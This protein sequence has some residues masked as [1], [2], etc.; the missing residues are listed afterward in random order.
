MSTRVGTPYVFYNV[1]GFRGG[2][3]KAV[4]SFDLLDSELRDAENVDFG[5]KGSIVPRAGTRT[6]D[7]GVG[8][9]IAADRQT[10]IKNIFR[11][12]QIDGKREVVIQS[13]RFIYND[14]DTGT[15]ANLVEMNQG[16]DGFIRFAQW[17]DTMF[18]F[19]K[20]DDVK[21]YHR[22]ADTVIQQARASG[23]TDKVF[24]V[25]ASPTDGGLDFP[26]TYYYRFTFERY[27]GDDFLGETNPININFSLFGGGVPDAS[28]VEFQQVRA[29]NSSGERGIVISS[30]FPPS[31]PLTALDDV[32]FINV[33]RST[34]RTS[35]DPVTGDAP[36]PLLEDPNF[37]FI[38]QF[39]REDYFRETGFSFKD[40]GQKPGH[41]IRYQKKSVPPRAKFAVM[42]KTRM[43]YANI[44]AHVNN[45]TPI[46]ANSYG[47]YYSDLLEPVAVR[48]LSTF[49]INPEDGEEIAQIVSW[50]GKALFV[51][52]D[53]SISAVFGGD[54]EAIDSIGRTSGVIDITIETIDTAVGC[55]APDSLAKGEGG[56]MFLSNRGVY[57]FNGVQAISLNSEIIEP[58]LDDIPSSMRNKAAGIYLNKERRYVL[59]ISNL[60]VAPSK[61]TVTLVYDFFTR[62]WTKYKFVGGT[63]LGINKYVELKRGDETG[64]LLGT[65][66]LSGTPQLAAGGTAI[67]GDVI[68]EFNIAMDWFATTK[69]FDCGKPHLVKNFTKLIIRYKS[70]HVLTIDYDVDEGKVV[71]TE[72]IP[73]SGIHTWDEPNLNWQGSSDPEVMETPTHLWAVVNQAETVVPLPANLIGR[74]ISFNFSGS[75]SISGTEIQGLTIVYEPEKRVANDG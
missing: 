54:N 62:T 5:L 21:T 28:L 3:N 52:K 46:D 44:G 23:V 51:F 8:D 69:F 60:S 29:T 22:G 31:A 43:W 50:K 59:A 47:I 6:Y 74:R 11:Y 55:I 40:V 57:F 38:G 33:Y 70:A 39:T 58:F 36:H 26:F 72:T 19:S 49:D 66:Q 67:I 37:F 53:N 1:D 61:N 41:L 63:G 45:N 35:S 20:N 30:A 2:L 75:E 65:L 56:I 73:I 32:R 71:G 17:R 64:K 4:A 13:E 7:V 10:Q 16:D 24:D 12:N 14:S 68:E 34:A 9:H 48:P 27:H 42:H 15:F 18:L 25:I